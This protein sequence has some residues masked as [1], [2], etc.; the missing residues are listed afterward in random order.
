M[1]ECAAC[2]RISANDA[3]LSP[4][5]DFIL[6]HAPV[7]A[8]TYPDFLVPCDERMYYGNHSCDANTLDTQLGFDVAVRDIETG[9][10][11][12]VDYRRFFDPT[13]A[14]PCRCGSALCCG[15]V[16]CAPPSATIAAMWQRRIA[17]AL[18]T[19]VAQPLLT[20]A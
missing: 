5:K 7:T 10:E 19:I 14:F 1:I 15:E 9:E 18:R 11:L 2:G 4:R 8:G 12:T 17:E 3:E 20:N 13:I 6:S 16:R